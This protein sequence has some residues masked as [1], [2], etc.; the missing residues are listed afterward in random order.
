MP[1]H[2][3]SLLTLTGGVRVKPRVQ[4]P[5][6][7]EWKIS[8]TAYW[9]FRYWK[10][11]IQSDGSLKPIR[12]KQICGPSKGKEAIS[13]REA[14]IIRDKFL[15]KLNAPTEKVALAKGQAL[16]RE[17]A[18]MYVES[19]LDRRGKLALPSRIKEKLNLNT[20]L[21]P[22]WGDKRLSEIKPKEIEDWL[23]SLKRRDGEF[24]SWWTMHGIRRTMSAIYHKAEDWGLWE[25]GKRNPLVKV[26]I[27][28]KSY[29]NARQILTWDQT[30]AVL[31]RLEDPNRLVIETCIG[32]STRISEVTGLMIKHFDPRTG[33]IKIEQRNW[34]MDI[35][36]PK[37]AGSKRTLALGALTGRFLDWI[38]KLERR[39]PNDWIFPQI[40][41]NSKPLWDSGL[42]D[43]LHQVA[44]DVGCDFAGLGPHSF[45]RANITW[46]QEVGGSAIEASKIAGHSELDMTGEYTF[47]ALDRQDALT[48]AIQ[49]RL[50]KAAPNGGGPDTPPT[51]PE[52]L[53]AG[54]AK[55]TRDRAKVIEI[56]R[57]E[58]AA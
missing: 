15:D 14:E 43:A 55:E 6:I 35:D 48:R 11:E 42:R 34:H 3:V 12:K 10:D 32:T 45:R 16:F 57:K 44:Q 9:F 33:T 49:E 30:A 13:K 8:K 5:K 4:H 20:Y 38:A 28:Q 56:R 50:A 36:E 19:H 7:H 25:E 41:D 22:Q 1:P 51:Q 2:E 54:R 53:A 31:A 58:S 46:R 21:V 40:R 52:Q 26:N 24:I 37:T 29:R 27:G 23:F 18:K 39:G 17:V 47:V